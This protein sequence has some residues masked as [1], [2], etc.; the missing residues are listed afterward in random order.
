MRCSSTRI[1]LSAIE[2][3]DLEQ[4]IDKRVAALLSF[5][6]ANYGHLDDRLIAALG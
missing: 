3:D 6:A 1:E 5:I 2:D 4:F